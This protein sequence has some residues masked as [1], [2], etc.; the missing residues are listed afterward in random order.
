VRTDVEIAVGTAQ[1]GDIFPATL[2]ED[3]VDGGRVLVRWDKLSGERS[4][5]RAV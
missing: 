1:P 4:G 3:I 5:P 2:D